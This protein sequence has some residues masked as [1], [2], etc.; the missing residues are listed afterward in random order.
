MPTYND[1][2][3]HKGDFSKLSETFEL[4]RQEAKSFTYRVLYGAALDSSIKT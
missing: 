2:I 3:N 1:I 4:T